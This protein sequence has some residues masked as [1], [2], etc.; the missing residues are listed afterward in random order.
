MRAEADAVAP[1]RR[2][3]LVIETVVV[4]CLC[5][6][7]SAF[8]SILSIIE[9]LTRGKPLNEQTTSMN[10]SVT[11]DR[12]WLDVTYQLANVFF[13]YVAPVA[14]V[15]LL[16]ACHRTPR[17]GW[18]AGL[19]FRRFT[20]KDAA[21]SLGL[22]AIIGIPG[23]ALYLGARAVGL[24]LNVSPGNLAEHW[25]TV[26]M[27][28]LLAFS[29][30]LL[31]EVVMIGYLFRRWR[32]AGWQVWQVVGLSALIRGTYHL[33][34]GFGGFVGNIAMG[35]IFG[36]WYVRSARGGNGPRVW[37]LVVAHTVIDVVAFVG[38][39]LLHDRIAWL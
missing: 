39:A 5:L 17:E 18:R 37:P 32:Q 31:E 6:G 2:R 38:Y 23:L 36:W 27:Y 33:Y 3:I 25:W 22:A 14:L 4:L 13:Y 15:C 29:N 21:R 12:S 1:S 16:V 9:S 26:P 10:R 30:G 24:N 8:Y 28:V 35:L 7:R 34:Q 20:G 19:G 11:P